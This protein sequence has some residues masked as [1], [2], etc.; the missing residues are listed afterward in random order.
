MSS[1]VLCETA[2]DGQVCSC[3]SR[4]TCVPHASTV[5]VMWAFQTT[6]VGI[7]CQRGYDYLHVC[8]VYVHPD[9]PLVHSYAPG[10]DCWGEIGEDSMLL[11]TLASRPVQVELNKFADNKCDPSA[12]RRKAVMYLFVANDALSVY[13]NEFKRSVLFGVRSVCRAVV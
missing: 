13:E 10:S 5:C 8:L 2:E 1:L 6:N 7:S 11:V 9:M 4:A 3:I 12:V